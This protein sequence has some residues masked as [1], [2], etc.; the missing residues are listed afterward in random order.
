MVLEGEPPAKIFTVGLSYW[1]ISKETYFELPRRVPR[2]PSDYQSAC[3]H[4]DVTSGVQPNFCARGDETS[5][6]QLPP[7][8]HHVRSSDGAHGAMLLGG[9]GD[10]RRR[11]VAVV[12][13]D[14][15]ACASAG[16]ARR[17]KPLHPPSRRA[18]AGV[19]G[20]VGGGVGAL[21]GGG[22][23]STRGRPS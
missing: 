14:R 1:R 23:T 5:R 18:A 10:A 4:E 11:D 13:A 6:K 3:E 2:G 8:H 16:G 21:S 9:A 20:V 17:F 15:G 19:V 7:I 12:D 22:G